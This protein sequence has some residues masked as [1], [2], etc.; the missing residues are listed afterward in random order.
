MS[1][2][3][4]FI[5]NGLDGSLRV[6]PEALDHLANH[7]EPVVVVSIVGLYRTGKSYLMNWLAGKVQGFSLGSTV[8]SHTKGIW[9]WCL[10]HPLKSN[11]SLML[12]DTEGL[13][14]VS[15]GDQKNDSWIF[16]LAVLLS[17]SLVYNSMGTID[18]YA[19][20]KLY[21]VTELTEL[22]K[23]K[24]SADF[25]EDDE[26]EYLKIFPT[27]VW[28]VRDFS[29]ELKIEGQVVNQDGYL[30]HALLLKK[31][32]SKKVMEYNLPRQC[33]RNFFP[34]RK[35]FVFVRPVS[36]DLH[37]VEHVPEQML[38]QSF[39]Q[40]CQRFCKYIHETSQPKCLQGGHI[41]TGRMLGMLASSY[42]SA[43]A[44]GAVPCLDDAVTSMARMENAVAVRLASDH[45]RQ[46]MEQQV[47]NMP[48]ETRELSDIHGN[49]EKEAL[50][51]F[52][53]RSFKDQH[54]EYQKQVVSDLA[55]QYLAVCQKNQQLSVEKCQVLLQSL[56]TEM[57]RKLQEG[58]YTLPGGYRL[59]VTDR[60]ALVSEYHATPGKGIQ[61]EVV[62]AEFLKRK[63][64]EADTILQAEKKLSEAEKLL[65]SE[66]DKAT[67]MEQVNKARE[68]ELFQLKQLREDERRTNEENLRQMKVKIVE[69]REEM[70]K[71][72]ERAL[73][74]LMAEQ[75]AVLEKG[76]QEK[77]ELMEEQIQQLKHQEQQTWAG[78]L[79]DIIDFMGILRSIFNAARAFA[80]SFIGEPD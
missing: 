64:I 46:Q 49:C 33:I 6:N 7:N 53:Q 40:E 43:I 28:C 3:L 66:A 24:A 74:S 58:V 9:M 36:R 38:D 37:T 31:G 62:L 32:N 20:E 59:Y 17:S 80:T 75:K 4:C 15:K 76:F 1:A 78:G 63:Q 30:E 16:A 56:S 72:Q 54:Q 44:T 52:M 5:E 77:A 70:L 73:E 41:I 26:I 69:E 61:A 51:V 27:F 29:L 22:I 21:F 2:P 57:H 34:K 14:D 18:Q 23:V 39:V 42:V 50:G 55:H 67:L 48:M 8:Q 19:L 79:V 10:P 25:H 13:G 12:L 45:Y 11:H 47:V 68:E 65:A 60:N 71:E 35:C